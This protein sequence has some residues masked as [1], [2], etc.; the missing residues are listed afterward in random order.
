MDDWSRP[1]EARVERTTN[2]LGLR[3]RL[4]NLPWHGNVHTTGGVCG[5]YR[6]SNRRKL[7]PA[8]ASA[9]ESKGRKKDM[10]ERGLTFWKMG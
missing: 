8:A 2:Y 7:I 3:S 10:N 1:L 9:L 6:R 5:L 4:R